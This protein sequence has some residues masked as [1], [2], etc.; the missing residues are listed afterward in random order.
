[1]LLSL[2]WKNIWRNKKRS[3]IIIAAITFGLW[4]G[5]FSS[6]IMVGMMESMVETS[7]SRHLS[8]IQI[9]KKD[10]EKDRDVRNYIPD[11]INVLNAT[12]TVQ[13]LQAASGRTILV[14]MAASPTSS[15]GVDIIGIVPEDSKKVTDIYANIIE[16]SYFESNR[17]NPILIGRK[18]AERLNLKINSKVVLSFQNLEGGIAYTACRVV[19][20]FK[21]NSF[22]STKRSCDSTFRCSSWRYNYD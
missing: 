13:G 15:Y 17:K 14:G 20:I 4:G 22:Y 11:G 5:I 1:M 3:L 8:H 12:R 10:Y 2:A 19:G 18:L 9:H 6:A 7:I 16:G 21:T